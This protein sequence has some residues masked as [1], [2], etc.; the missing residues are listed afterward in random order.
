MNKKVKLL[1][2]ILIVSTTTFSQS[3]IQGIILNQQTLQPI[4]YVNIKVEGNNN[5]ATSAGDGYFEIKTTNPKTNLVLT[6][7][8]YKKKTLNL[9]S[10]KK[11]IDIG[12][13]YLQPIP[14]PLD[15]I[16]INAGLSNTKEL[17]VSIST[18]TAL[19]IETKLGDRPLP[20]IMRT[21]PGVFSV[22]DGGGSG[23]AKLSIRG[24]NQEN[25]G[26][27]LNGIP[28]NG[29]ENG[30]VYWSNW[31]GLSTTA[32][33]IQIQKGPGLT[34]ASISAIGGSVNIITRNAQ[35]QKSTSIK[36]GISSFGNLLTSIAINSGTMS[37]GW[38]T[39]IMLSYGS[40][41]G[42]VDATSVKS[43]S[44]FFTAQKNLNDNHKLTITLLGAPQTHEQQ[45]IRL[46]SN[47]IEIHGVVYNKDWGS[48]NGQIKN[49]S[50][51]FYH[52]PFL[53]I[54]DDYK[55]NDKNTLSTSI[56]FSIGY[57][58]GR[59]SESFNYAPSIFTY[60]NYSG[61]INWDQIYENNATHEGSYTLE[62]GETVRGYSLNVQTNYIASHIQTG[63]VSNFEHKINDNLA[64]LTGLHYRY[65]NSYV[66]E[67]I[68]ELLGGEFFIEDY[69]WSLAGVANR[70][71]I[72]S[73]GDIIHVDNNSII[74]FVNTYL[75]LVY[76]KNK[77]N[78]FVSANANNNWYQR[79]DRFNY[80]TNT[81]SETVLKPG[82]DL[83]AGF[84]YK[85]NEHNSIYINAAAISRAPY[86]KYVF[87]NYTNVVV[88]NLNNETI[89]TIEIGYKLNRNKITSNINTYY[90]K[91]QNVSTL[92]NEYIQLENNMQTRA[93]IN[94]LNALHLGLEFDFKY[95]LGQNTNI[96]AML[97]VG[98]FTWQNNVSARLFNDNNVVVDTVNVYA[99]GLFIGGTAQQ[100][101]GLFADFALLKTIFLKA[102]LLY[103]SSLYSN[104]DAT[105]RNNPNDISQP[106]QLPS[107]GIINTYI[108]IP[109]AINKYHGNAQISIFNLLNKKYIVLGQDG[110]DHNL[111]TFRGFWSFGR[112]FTFSVKFSF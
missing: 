75:Q 96:G 43:Y 58:G 21:T 1:I 65:F 18:I 32:A 68:D 77:I 78:A 37:S 34:N 48:Y 11:L 73:V 30:L 103:F 88:Q 57:G 83:R 66:R 46:S 84:L 51:N 55:I 67:E 52:K 4:Q 7:I 69:A 41:P 108:S 47:E 14:Y 94:G 111:E 56:Y 6:S 24:F 40:G 61:Q 12:Q 101:Y 102:E 19:E 5:G 28:I 82:W 71:Q 85:L 29:Q 8:G 45:T 49:A 98:N 89:Q 79:V 15:E 13:I 109:F 59:W 26:L 63:L 31:L 97:A 23:D 22:K 50:V 99:K 74:N 36:F 10:H 54:N 25:V 3:T 9:K 16:L 76:N 64:L 35:K 39:S 27:L 93:M 81:K 2:V 91:R 112:N 62:N 95:S 90:T 86:F 92:S 110:S 100:Q 107:Y 87:G 104:F 20:L 80:I 106:F 105:S 70:N 72:K 42:Y 60:R 17:P 38:C 33:E 44:Y 53:S